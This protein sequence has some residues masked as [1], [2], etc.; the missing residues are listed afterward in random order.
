MAVVDL[1]ATRNR[2]LE[3][4]KLLDEVSIT[5]RKITLNQIMDSLNFKVGSFERRTYYRDL[6][7]LNEITNLSIRFSNRLKAYKI[8]RKEELSE[9]E[10]TIIVNA[11][12]SARFDSEAETRTLV[13]KLYSL[14]GQSKMPSGEH[15]IEN[16]IKLGDTQDT[17][18]KIDFIQSAIC[19]KKR[20]LFDYQK[21]NLTKNYEIIRRDCLV[22]PY[23]F[24]WHNDKMYLIGNFEGNSF[25]HY[26]IER[27]CNYRETEKKCKPIRE[28]IGYGRQ[29][30]EAEYLRKMSEVSSGK[31]ERVVINFRNAELGNVLDVFG[32]NVFIKDNA[33]E[34][35]KLDDNIVINKKL[36]RWIL[37]FGESA[38]V[39]KPEGLRNKITEVMRIMG[40]N[41]DYGK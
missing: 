23:K 26:R 2:L 9:S 1:D 19:E 15:C 40:E 33:D 4:Y 25:S 38:E 37:G 31:I 41:Y 29:F 27:I 8:E 12:L 5:T 18:V 24:L 34:T 39:I 22:S 3:L 20:I 30:D 32:K 28:I 21:F 16:R 10:L 35:F 17:L 7:L 11:I 36:I 6:S 14:V 13:D